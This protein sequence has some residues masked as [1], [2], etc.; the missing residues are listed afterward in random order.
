MELLVYNKWDAHL[1]T[2]YSMAKKSTKFTEHSTFYHFRQIAVGNYG[3]NWAFLHQNSYWLT[4]KSNDA[5]LDSIH[6]VTWKVFSGHFRG[7]NIQ[8]SAFELLQRKFWPFCEEISI[9]FQRSYRVIFSYFRS[10]PVIFEINF[11]YQRKFLF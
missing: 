5:T 1:E 4:N 2:I 8:Y 9:I 6:L 10:F 7:D 3:Q 11:D